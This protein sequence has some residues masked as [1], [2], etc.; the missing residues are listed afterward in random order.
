MKVKQLNLSPLVLPVI[1]WIVGIFI[2]KFVDIPIITLSIA[3]SVCF[4]LALIK[5]LRIIFLPAAIIILGLFRVSILNEFPKDHI[6]SI[7]RNYPQ[8]TQLVEG[9]IV[10]EVVS[11]DNIR[12]FTLELSRI[13][14][15]E[16]KGKIIFS[17]KQKNL[18]YGDL[19]KVVAIIRKLNK[20]SNPS[21]FDYEEYLAAK[22][23]YATG[24]SKTLIEVYGSKK[25]IFPSIAINSRKALRKRINDRF[26]K[27]R[28]FVK[29]IVIGDKTDLE[30]QRTILNKAGLSHLLA[31]SG[32]HVGILSLVI[33]LFLNI[34]IPNRTISRFLL[35]IIL[36]IYGAICMWSPSVT[37]AVLMIS[38]YLI[39]KVIQRRPDA[40]NILAVSLL[41]ITI[42]QPLQLFSVGLQMSYMAVLVL[43]NVLPS[44]RFIKFKKEEIDV[45][46]IGKKILNAVL[47]L[48]VSSL[49]LN[50][51]LSPITLLYF[52]Q[53]NLNGMVGNLL[54]I[55][56]ISL[57][58]PLTLVVIFLPDFG[59]LVQIYQS[60]FKGVMFFF[61]KWT[62]FSS[63]LPMHFDFIHINLF[64]FF[65]FYFILLFIFLWFRNFRKKTSYVYI[66]SIILLIT[67]LLFFGN[68]RTE[69]LKITFFDCGLGDL[70]LIETPEGE[71]VLI[72]SGPTESTPRHF[73]SSALPYF[74]DN[75]LKSL[76][77]VVITHAHNDHYGGLAFVLDNLIVK[78]LVI[79]DEFKT[80]KIWKTLTPR[81]TEEQC[82]IITICDTTHLG[83]NSIKTKILH[84]DKSF[85]HRN[86]NNLSIVVRIDYKEFSV[87]FTGDL[88]VE[89]EEYLLEKYPEFLDCDILKVGH[90]GSKTSSSYEFLKAV[91]PVQAFISTALKNRFNFPHKVTLEK[92]EFLGN[93][94]FIS[95][96]DGALQVTTDGIAANF[97]TYLSEKEFT[98]NDLTQTE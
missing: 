10:S 87:L 44:F 53:F 12:R 67:S 8:F 42:F 37:R 27:F 96:K 11:K 49:I 25:N 69:K 93:N 73:E 9:R 26:G 52:N 14:G 6:R 40:N 92:Y 58:L 86:I 18:Q 78:N 60:A 64:Q 77:W 70:A 79:T 66:L 34:I 85:S 84:P 98:D 94:L 20:S 1:F 80:R 89:G 21:S 54:G 65:I 76:D 55:P 29:A 17:T 33:F 51:F 56:L 24:Y 4:L 23:I 88:E 90:H 16:A 81:I 41:I 82:N 59:F 91:T 72:D 83:L 63:N 28:G 50:I 61:D 35:M 15:K 32:L 36:F 2:G 46:R 43:L 30:D 71:T 97:K 48:L 5:K 39:S 38:L 19:I 68:D 7:I 31:V 22:Q 13:A 75:G 95:G 3:F 62:D 57:L 45:L 47:I 74:K